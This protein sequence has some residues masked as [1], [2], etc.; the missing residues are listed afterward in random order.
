MEDLDVSVTEDPVSGCWWWEKYERFPSALSAQISIALN[1]DEPD[2]PLTA[3]MKT[4]GAEKI[5]EALGSYV[6]FLK[7]GLVLQSV[8]IFA[9][10]AGFN[11]Y[12]MILMQSSRREWSCPQPTVS[13][14]L[15]A[16]RSPKPRWIKCRSV[17]TTS[18]SSV[19]KLFTVAAWFSLQR[20]S[21]P[22]ETFPSGCFEQISSSSSTAAPVN[23]GV[24]I[25]TC[26]FTLKDKFL[27]SP[28]DLYRVFL[29]Q[30]VGLWWKLCIL[31]DYLHSAVIICWKLLFHDWP[32]GGLRVESFFKNVHCVEWQSFKL[33]VKEWV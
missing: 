3:L 2:T 12:V 31:N 10:K 18:S 24:K 26:K 28:A 6:G 16:P 13:P 5:R 8:S 4:K 30:E 33:A 15:R 20:C 21:K 11:L 23:T 17:L 29:N 27:T 14:R 9:W 22:H 19:P 7:S 32:L 1:K 25:P